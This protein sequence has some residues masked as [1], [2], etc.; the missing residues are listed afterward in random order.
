M[1]TERII[2]TRKVDIQTQTL[3]RTIF[4]TMMNFIAMKILAE[5]LAKRGLASGKIATELRAV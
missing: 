1:R 2:Q 3:T 5:A 4:L